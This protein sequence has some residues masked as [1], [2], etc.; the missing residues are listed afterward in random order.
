MRSQFTDITVCVLVA[1]ILFF[2]GSCVK[3][4]IEFVDNTDGQDDPNIVFI[5]DTKVDIAT[6]KVDSFITSGQNLFMIGEHSDPVFGKIVAGSFAQLLL[7]AANEVKDLDVT[8]DSIVMILK[9]D[10]KYYGDT[11]RFFE[12][13]VHRLTQKIKNED[14]VANFYQPA[15]FSY[16][17]R[18]MGKVRTILR[19]NAGKLLNIRMDDNWGRELLDKLKNDDEDIARNDNFV[20]YF[21]GVHL[22]SAS[23][24]NNTIYYFLPDSGSNLVRLYYHVNSAFPIEKHLDLSV[25]PGK[26]FSRIESDFSGT[27]LSVF[28]A[29][30][31]KLIPSSETGGKSYINNN[32]GAYIKISFPDILRLKELYPYINVMKAELIVYPVP[33][34]YTYPYKLP[35]VIPLYTTDDNHLP[36]LQLTD[37]VFQGPL[38]GNL[39]IDKLYGQ[40]TKYTY[41]ITGFVRNLIS[42][43]VFS[44]SALL[45][46]P[47]NGNGPSGIQRLVINEQGLNKGIELKLYVLG[48]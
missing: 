13:S 34:T 48:L 3:A 24:V 7:P 14:D 41:N 27:N 31:N 36:I 25:E 20:N 33:G 6:Y 22:K 39:F 8:F 12:M 15:S 23:S 32:L 30:K 10:G 1:F 11:A 17:D 46:A 2:I 21:H 28:P 44:E 47:Q 38:T 18:F 40:N 42:E 16:E 19:P 4:P 37:P 45:L 9:P 35:D 5:D 43:G 26:Q 29:F